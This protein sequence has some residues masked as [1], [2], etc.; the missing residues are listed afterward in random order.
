[1][2]LLLFRSYHKFTPFSW[3]K[4]YTF[5]SKCI[6]SYKVLPFQEILDKS[7]LSFSLTLYDLTKVPCRHL[8]PVYIV[9]SA[10][11]QAYR[12][13]AFHWHVEIRNI[14]TRRGGGTDSRE[15]TMAGLAF[16]L[17]VFPYSLKPSV[18]RISG[19]KN[20]GNATHVGTVPL[21]EGNRIFL[22]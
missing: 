1:M 15:I 12:H 11:S 18:L 3:R 2:D 8:P 17:S 6:K 21:P 7:S 14:H 4:K 20:S 5:S 10:W 16:H 22:G 9:P 13:L 19:S